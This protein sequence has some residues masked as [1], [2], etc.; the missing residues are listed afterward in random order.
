[1]R[2]GSNTWF[3]VRGRAADGVLKVRHGVVQEIG[4]ADRRLTR[5][6]AAARRFLTSFG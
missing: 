5:G 4:L 2:V 1:V 6:R 3:V